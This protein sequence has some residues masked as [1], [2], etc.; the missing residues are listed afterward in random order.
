[1]SQQINLVNPELRPKRELLTAVFMVKVAGVFAVLLGWYG[2]VL[3]HE[4]AQLKQQRDRLEELAKTEQTRL[5]QVTQQNP[6]K[7]PSDELK[8]EIAAATTS[9]SE[10]Q[11][12]LEILKSGITGGNGGFYDVLQGFARQSVNGLWL[13]GIAVNGAGDQ[14]RISGR[15]VSP[16]LIPQYIGKLSGE[17]VLRGRRFTAFEAAQPKPEPAAAN[18]PD[19][20]ANTKAA[21]SVPAPSY[22]EF[23]LSAGKA[24][25]QEN[26]DRKNSGLPPVQ[27]AKS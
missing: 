17:P 7:T 20:A 12:V 24:P 3:M 22:I 11:Q 23:V 5:V 25:A 15:A 14:M 18:S 9:V 27:E 13:T 19:S 10:H 21:P 16:D 1:M 26:G 4:T 8:Q 2:W 6:P